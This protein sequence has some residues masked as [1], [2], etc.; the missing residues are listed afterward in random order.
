MNT[1]GL[2]PDFTKG[3]GLLPCIVQ[4][5]ATGAVLMLG[6]MNAEALAHTLS[7]GRVT[8]F[9]RTRGKLWTKG[10]TSGYFL[11]LV[12]I[13]DDCDH[14]TLLATA[15]PAGPVCHMGS[16]TCFGEALSFQPLSFLE[17][18]INDRFEQ[19]AED[20]YTSALFRKGISSIAQK[21]GEEAVELILEAR[22]GTPERFLEEAADLLFHYL[23]LLRS[24]N[25]TLSGVAGVLERR[26]TSG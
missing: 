19:P 23:V 8:F 6:Y 12:D 3:S 5:S 1:T 18:V 2:Q 7:T 9:S 20:S 24:R 25:M 4:H 15:V 22:D 26:H 14:D 17:K 21:V 13:R 10:E 11:K 16:E